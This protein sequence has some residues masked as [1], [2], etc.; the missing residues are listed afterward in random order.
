M[1]NRKTA[2]ALTVV[3]LL[4]MGLGAGVIWTGSDE[5]EA[6]TSD[7]PVSSVIGDVETLF[8]TSVPPVLT[9]TQKVANGTYFNITSTQN[10]PWE[11]LVRGINGTAI[12][13]GQSSAGLSHTAQG[14]SGVLSTNQPTVTIEWEAFNQTEGVD[15]EYS[16]VFTVVDTGSS[17]NNPYLDT[18]SLPVKIFQMTQDYYAN[19]GVTVNLTHETVNGL[20]YGV[21]SVTPGFGLTVDSNTT[22]LSGTISGTGTITIET[23]VTDGMDIEEETHTIYVS[24]YSQID[25]R[26]ISG[27]TWTYTPITNIQSVI[28][29]SGTATSWVSLVNGVIS[30]TAPSV[31][32]VGQ[33]YELIITA[34]STQPVQTI[35]QTVTFT[36]DPPIELTVASDP[37]VI[38]AEAGSVDVVSSNFEG[39]SRSIYSISGTAGY[40]INA[41]TGVISYTNPVDGY[42]TIT[43]TSPYAYA[44][45]ATN[46]ASAWMMFN[47]RD[48]GQTGTV[49]EAVL[50]LYVDENTLDQT[51]T[52]AWGTYIDLTWD[53]DDIAGSTTITGLNTGLLTSGNRVYGY[54]SYT[55]GPTSGT[56]VINVGSPDSIHVTLNIVD[57]SNTSATYYPEL[58]MP[59]NLGYQGM[60]PLYVMVGGSVLITPVTIGGTTY[61]VDSVSSGY[62][63]S[64][65]NGVLSG[66]I[67][68]AGTITVVVDETDFEITAVPAVVLTA[69]V[70]ESTIYLVTG[71][72]VP[73]TPAEGVTLSHNDVGQGTYTWS[74]VGTNNTGVTVTAGGVLG[75]TPGAVG[76][77]SIT[78]RCTSNVGGYVQT[79][80]V[81]L[82]VVIVPVLAFTSVPPFAVS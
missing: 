48:S 8:Y 55:T 47:V 75:G 63:L 31:A 20:E 18:I 35:T 19:V 11:Y 41:T 73:N 74:I 78:L 39:G 80:D 69:S 79:A 44:S 77:Y 15:E 46:S 24:D 37:Q 23:Y 14:I 36:V 61:G 4:T 62:G 16:S 81:T 40:N 43:A 67:T 72:T 50:N 59:A 70:S 54:I 53:S 10:G 30:G 65:S 26:M 60:S 49:P 21:S 42:V 28:S 68:Q 66:T 51:F 9:M 7:T 13:V 58:K 3:M 56:A 57:L 82:G 22:S 38:Q 76:T 34:N 25:V 2:S 6:V 33:Q 45:G 29:I 64:V 32:S 52:V 5:S 12:H 1:I 27:E 71:K 17:Q